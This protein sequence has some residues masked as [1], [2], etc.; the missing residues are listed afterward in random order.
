M[1]YD[2]SIHIRVSA[3]EADRF[4]GAASTWYRGNRTDFVRDAIAQHLTRLYAGTT[5][6]SPAESRRAPS[7]A[8]GLDTND[9]AE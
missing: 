4:Q 3:D 2:H 6:P 1:R 8:S 9:H 7:A 5:S